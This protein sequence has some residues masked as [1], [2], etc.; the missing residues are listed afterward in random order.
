[1]EA[2]P[3]DFL[4]GQE[5]T[6]QSYSSVGK[7]TRAVADICLFAA[8]IVLLGLGAAWLWVVAF[9]FPKFAE[10][11]PGRYWD[12]LRS[13]GV[14]ALGIAIVCWIVSRRYASIARASRA[15]TTDGGKW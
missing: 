2:N 9:G 8:I 7:V 5:V 1:M 14:W 4:A 15:A 12:G 3:F 13:A 11:D 6:T 10:A